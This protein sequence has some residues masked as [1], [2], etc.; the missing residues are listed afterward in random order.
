MEEGLYY[1][2]AERLRKIFPSKFPTIESARPYC[3]MPKELSMKLYN[4]FHGRGGI[5][6]TWEENYRTHGKKLGYDYVGSP[7]MLLLPKHAML[8]SGSYWDS[9]DCNDVADDMD[10]VTLRVN[11]KARMHLAERIAYRNKALE[12]L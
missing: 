11:G 6:L 10:E 1:R 8:V 12:I 3:R 9:R 2:D 5:Q 4:G 7:N